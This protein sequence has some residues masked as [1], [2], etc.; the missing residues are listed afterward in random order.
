MQLNQPRCDL[1]PG[2]LLPTFT[3]LV[4]SS[5]SLRI[6]SKVLGFVSKGLYSSISFQRFANEG[7]KKQGDCESVAIPSKIRNLPTHWS[8]SIGLLLELEPEDDSSVVA[9]VALILIAFS[10]AV[11]EPS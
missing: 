1:R 5:K 10:K 6:L 7:G 9:K 11:A 3:G 8:D 2:P 4:T